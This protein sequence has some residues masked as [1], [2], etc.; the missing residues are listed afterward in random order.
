MSLQAFFD[1]YGQALAARDVSAIAD[2]WAI[3]AFV[4]GPEDGVPVAGRVEVETFFTQSL[5]QYDGIAGARPNL[6]EPVELM[7]GVF[8]C[9]VAWEHLDADGAVIGGENGFYIVRGA[10]ADW[11]IQ[12]Y[13]PRI[14]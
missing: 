10:D 12:V 5:A 1:R 11:T 14:A 2:A 7:P 13:A 6:S 3:P 4:I 8:A 9:D